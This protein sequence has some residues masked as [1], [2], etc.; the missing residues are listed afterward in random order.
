VQFINL[1]SSYAQVA[2]PRTHDAAYDHLERPVVIPKPSESGSADIPNYVRCVSGVF[3]NLAGT[4][5]E[6]GKHGLAVRFLKQGCAL[7]VKALNMTLAG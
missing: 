5:Y 3:H 7:G 1:G 2:D 4:L 6:G